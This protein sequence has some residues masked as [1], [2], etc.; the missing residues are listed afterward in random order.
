MGVCSVGMGV[1]YR[2]G[3]L[4]SDRLLEYFAEKWLREQ[5]LKLC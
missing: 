2:L 3:G 4:K 1:F 5:A